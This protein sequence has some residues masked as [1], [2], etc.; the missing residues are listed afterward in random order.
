[1]KEAERLVHSQTEGR[2]RMAIERPE[3][4]PAPAAPLAG[5]ASVPALPGKEHDSAITR[6]VPVMAS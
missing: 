2:N 6:P 4:L 3:D 1:M 5:A